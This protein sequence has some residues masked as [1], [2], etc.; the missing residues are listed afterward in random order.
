MGIA[1]RPQSTNEVADD[2]NIAILHSVDDIKNVHCISMAFDGLA[3]E[4]YFIRRNLISFMKGNS[5]IVVMTDHNHAAKN[6]RSQL[7]LGSDIVTGGKAIFDVG[8]LRLAGISV[9]LYRVSDYASDILVLKLCS[10]DTINKLMDLVVTSKKDP[11]N[12]AFL[13]ITLYF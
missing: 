3:A 12:V 10:S 11:L 5:N 7:V 6:I 13:A 2:Y 8:I 4:I 9:D 1:A